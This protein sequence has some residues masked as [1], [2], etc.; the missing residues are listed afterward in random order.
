MTM[1]YHYKYPRALDSKLKQPTE[2]SSAM[3]VLLFLDIEDKNK[4]FV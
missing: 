3:Y 1:S 4:Q 2:S